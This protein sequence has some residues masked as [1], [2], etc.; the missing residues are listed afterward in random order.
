LAEYAEAKNKKAAFSNYAGCPQQYYCYYYCD[1]QTGAARQK[2]FIQKSAACI[3]NQYH[4]PFLCFDS[5]TTRVRRKK[6]NSLK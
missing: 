4:D 5:G 1:D 2:M 3:K 6:E